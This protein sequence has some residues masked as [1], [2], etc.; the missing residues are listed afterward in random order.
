MFV[1][2]VSYN[3][4]DDFFDAVMIANVEKTWEPWLAPLVFELPA[5]RSVIENLRERLAALNLV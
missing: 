4:M 2:N 5:F 1:K 3:T